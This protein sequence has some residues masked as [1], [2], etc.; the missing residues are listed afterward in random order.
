MVG[1]V[2]PSEARVGF[3]TWKVAIER[4]GPTFGGLCMEDGL[5][6]G[7]SKVSC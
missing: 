3:G 6:T 1:C 2:D 7:F 5:G 4:K